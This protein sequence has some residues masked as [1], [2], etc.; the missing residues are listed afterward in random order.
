MGSFYTNAICALDD[1]EIIEGY[2]KNNN[3]NAFLL[4]KVNEENY[5]VITEERC[6]TLDFRENNLFFRPLSKLTKSPILGC[7]VHDSDD[8]FLCLFSAGKDIYELINSLEY[9]DDGK[10]KYNNIEALHESFSGNL[11][12]LK[13]LHTTQNARKHAFVEDYQN[14]IYSSIN[15]PLWSIGIGYNYLSR[16]PQLIEELNQKGIIVNEYK[17]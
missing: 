16:E 7:I 13:R 15:V 3:R 5:I 10:L 12:D 2:I 1:R 9:S 4:S 8:L 17:G 11:D 6:D 14:E